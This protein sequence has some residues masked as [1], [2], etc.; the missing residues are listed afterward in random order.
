[1]YS[2]ATTSSMALR[3]WP[4]LEGLLLLVWV[5]IAAVVSSER[6][7][8]LAVVVVFVAALPTARRIRFSVWSGRSREVLA[9][10][11]TRCGCGRGLPA[12]D[13]CFGNSSIRHHSRLTIATLPPPHDTRFSSP[14]KLLLRCAAQ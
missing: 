2:R 4:D 3:P 1:M 14:V 11:S 7:E 5:D 12:D 13:E 6:W 9:C 10:T 8:S